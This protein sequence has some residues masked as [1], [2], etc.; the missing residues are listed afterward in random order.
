MAVENGQGKETVKFRQ[1]KIP[2]IITIILVEM[3]HYSKERYVIPKN[4]P[5]TQNGLNGPNVLKVVAG[6]N[7]PENGLAYYHQYLHCIPKA[8]YFAMDL[9]SNLGKAY[10]SILFRNMHEVLC[11]M[12]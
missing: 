5:F 12:E 3:P 11:L 7:N 8:N 4:A 1:I 9:Q 2:K 10:T 6:V